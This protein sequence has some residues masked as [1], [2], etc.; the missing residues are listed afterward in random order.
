MS[1]SRLP[2]AT[3]GLTIVGLLGTLALAST[4]R[5][6]VRVD[7]GLVINTR[8]GY[9]FALPKGWELQADS[10]YRNLKV[11]HSESGSWLSVDYDRARG[12]PNAYF[13][14]L[15]FSFKSPSST[16]SGAEIKDIAVG[17]RPGKEARKVV[18]SKEGRVVDQRFAFILDGE[19]V[20]TITSSVPHDQVAERA[21]DVDA[22][23][24]SLGWGRPPRPE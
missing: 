1:G 9:Y 13:M 23:I 10:D 5:G 7:N 18:K 19:Y 3:M 4:Q 24:S 8:V 20:Y 11:L 14:A 16:S 2:V 21:L 12:D 22:M 6:P 15:V 17:G